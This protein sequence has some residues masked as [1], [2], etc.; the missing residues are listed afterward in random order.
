MIGQLR[1]EM[2]MLRGQLT[3]RTSILDPVPVQGFTR[4]VTDS[5]PVRLSKWTSVIDEPVVV[6][7]KGFA[8]GAVMT[9]ATPAVVVHKEE[10]FVVEAP[11][12]KEKPTPAPRRPAKPTPSPAPAVVV[13]E[14]EPMKAAPNPSIIEGYTRI[15]FP[16]RH[17]PDLAKWFDKTVKDTILVPDL[18]PRNKFSS[19]LMASSGSAVAPKAGHV[20]VFDDRVDV[21][22]IDQL[23]LDDLVF[24]LRRLVAEKVN[25]ASAY[26]YL[27]NVYV[28]ICYYVWHILYLLL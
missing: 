1:A 24:D 4:A 25:A 6:K 10:T 17:N 14:R 7:E 27:G 26:V 13:I 15:R 22:V 8:A 28:T 11:V 3:T 19:P 20:L 18:Q 21:W 16:S 2:D 12:V 5:H 9:S 23:N